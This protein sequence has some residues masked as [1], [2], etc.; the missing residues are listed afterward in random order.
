[1]WLTPR[2]GKMN[3]TDESVDQIL[4]SLIGYPS[5]QDGTILPARCVLQEEFPRKPYNKSFIDQVCRRPFFGETR[6]KRTWSTSSHLD[7]TLGE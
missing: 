6:E 1:M 3:Q 7:L 5:R 2:A 4:L